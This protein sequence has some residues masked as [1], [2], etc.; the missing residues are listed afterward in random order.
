MCLP[1]AACN[2]FIRCAL[3]EQ[4]AAADGGLAYRVLQYEHQ[5]EHVG[6]LWSRAET[7]WDAR[8]QH[9]CADALQSLGAVCTPVPPEQMELDYA[10][11][12]DGERCILVEH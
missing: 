2:M 12:M 4:V 8:G 1:V 11:R 10:C 3:A 6:S 5:P 7:C 9:R